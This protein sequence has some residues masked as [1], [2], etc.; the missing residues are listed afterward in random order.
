MDDLIFALARAIDEGMNKD[1][2]EDTRSF[3]AARAIIASLHDMVQ[4][5]EWGRLAEDNG[6]AA[7]SCGRVYYALDDG[8]WY[9]WINGEREERGNENN[10]KSAKAAA[11]AHHT[12]QIMKALGV[13]NE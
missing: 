12:A 9:V 4:P 3:T 2:D 13:S 7:V 6:E 10:L 1:D 11:Q 5:L 8:Y